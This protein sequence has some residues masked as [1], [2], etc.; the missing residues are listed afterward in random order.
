M[1]LGEARELKSRLR[2]QKYPQIVIK[3]T[4]VDEA[5]PRGFYFLFF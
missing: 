1:D 3:A 2:R 4:E 5:A